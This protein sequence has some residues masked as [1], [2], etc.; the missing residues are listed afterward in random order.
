[1]ER[2]RLQ[3]NG[4]AENGSERNVTPFRTVSPITT[5]YCLERSQGLR[6]KKER[7]Q[8]SDADAG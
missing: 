7:T 3:H 2:K 5:C 1:M 8:C 4:L 6:E